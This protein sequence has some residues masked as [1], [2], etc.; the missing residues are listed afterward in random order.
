LHYRL[1]ANSGVISAE[2]ENSSLRTNV[3][4][5]GA[6]YTPLENFAFRGGIDRLDF[7]IMHRCETNLWIYCQKFIHYWTPSLSYAYVFES[8]APHGMHII[9]LSTIF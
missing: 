4:R 9:T 5:I 3:I 2:F 1:P 8:F 7:G 6:E